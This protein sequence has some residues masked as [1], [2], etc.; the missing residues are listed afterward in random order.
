MA[1][2]G[3]VMGWSG[4]PLRI[5]V[6]VDAHG[7]EREERGERLYAEFVEELRKVC[8]DPRFNNDAIEVTF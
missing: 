6:R 3:L 4:Y 2:K 8:D 5:N 1:G 7:G